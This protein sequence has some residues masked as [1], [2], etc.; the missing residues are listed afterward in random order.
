MPPAWL[1]MDE[2][3]LQGRLAEPQR[4]LR[5]VRRLTGTALHSGAATHFTLQQSDGLLSQPRRSPPR[6]QSR[7]NL[8]LLLAA[9]RAGTLTNWPRVIASPATLGVGRGQSSRSKNR[10]NGAN[11][12]RSRRCNRGRTPRN[13]TLL[14][15]HGRCRPRRARQGKARPF[16]RSGSQKTCL[17]RRILE[18]S[19]RGKDVPRYDSSA[20]PRASFPRLER[21]ARQGAGRQR[22]GGVAFL[23]R[24]A[25]RPFK[26]TLGNLP[27]PTAVL[28]CALPLTR[29][30][31]A[32]T[33][34]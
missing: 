17:K 7:R 22:A 14:A 33:R 29:E 16:A 9:R 27:P 5:L 25:L 20:S 6:A 18:R 15:T 13:A 2:P 24:H 21:P 4:R 31:R 34:R 26:S 11:P 32:I 30:R 3:Y 8:D 28:P 19:F 1:L 10:E 23:S 12:L